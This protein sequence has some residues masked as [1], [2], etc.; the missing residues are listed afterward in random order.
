M[1]LLALQRGHGSGQVDEG[2]V[3]EADLGG[4]ILGGDEP[5]P[6]LLEIVFC[7]LLAVTHL[8]YVLDQDS[9]PCPDDLAKEKRT[10][11]PEPEPCEA[12]E[13]PAKRSRR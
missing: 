6:Y 1:R 8:P 9:P 11:A 10:S 7:L 5:R 12:S 13:P 2:L 4:R 3:M